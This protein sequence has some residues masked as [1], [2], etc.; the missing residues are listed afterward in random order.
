MNLE[1]TYVKNV[2]EEIANHFDK[3]QTYLW[4]GIKQFLLDIPSDSIILDSG[5]GN[6]KNMKINNNSQVIGFDFCEKSVNICKNKQ[7]EVLIANTRTI[8]FRNN[9][10]DY[11]IS[12]AVLHHIS[13]NRQEVI[14]ELIR[15]LKPGGKIFIQV[16]NNNV[17]KNKKF[18]H[19]KDNDYFITWFVNKNKKLKRYYHLFEKNEFIALFS[20]VKILDFQEELDNYYIIGEKL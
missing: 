2:Y 15:V 14:N 17:K 5:C 20:S 19:I 7:L 11:V 6:G 10:Y 9:I 18:I 3:T 12:I 13:E 1:Q 16:W 4:Y 8:P